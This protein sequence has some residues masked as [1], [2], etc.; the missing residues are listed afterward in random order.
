M[1]ENGAAISH[2][3]ALARAFTPKDASLRRLRNT[4]LL[5]LLV[6]SVVPLLILSAYFH[7]QFKVTLTKRSQ[8]QLETLASSHRGAVDRFIQN[9]VSALSGIVQSSLIQLPPSKS[10]VEKLHKVLQSLDETILDV[11]V[12]DENGRHVAYAGPFE[13]LEGRDYRNEPWFRALMETERTSYVSD[14]YLGYRDEP[15]FV[16]AVKAVREA[17]TWVLR[18][19]VNL[20]K[21]QQFVDEVSLIAQ[22]RGFLVNPQGVYQ[23][24]PSDLGSPLDDSPL[25]K[26][27]GR[28]TEGVFETE[29][30]GEGYLA[31]AQRLTRVDWTLVVIQPV[32]AAYAPIARA[33]VIVVLII[34]FGL[35]VTVVA[36]WLATSTLMRQ[37]SR[38]EA[39]RAEL[40]SQLVQAGKMTTMGEMAA[41][42][43][44]EVN[45]PLAIILSEIGVMEDVLDPALGQAFDPDDFL[46]R[47][48]SIREESNRCRGIIHKLLGFARR[49]KPRITD[50]DLGAVIDEAMDMVGKELSLENIEMRVDVADGLGPI[51]TDEDQLRQVLINLVR[52][53]ADAIGKGGAISIQAHDVGR[54]VSLSVAD[55]GCGISPENIEQIFMP[56][57][58]TK[59]VGKGTGL[60][61]SITHGI[62]TAL[63]GTIKVTSEVGQGTT[64][65]I[66]LP[67]TQA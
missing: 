24:T 57:F 49:N 13:F 23:V 2:R 50:C 38:S 28:Q 55:T 14:V 31:A 56:F 30:D 43:A 26:A 60:G 29:V 66:L 64:F 41:G 11:G 45:N 52:N 37:Y 7:H 62:V 12:F 53:A 39:N 51:R 3:A 5:R 15:H 27:S 61:L 6:V 25:W 58:T 42:V 22:L 65:E 35:A 34:V 1:A 32:T 36:A 59:E 67:K 8:L 47:L 46:R 33:Q 19:T 63:G 4:I 9:K 40:I 54:Q 21:F 16:I 44:H 20:Q 48:N 18:L 17:D 10:E